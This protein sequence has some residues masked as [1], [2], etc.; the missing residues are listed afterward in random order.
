MPERQWQ[1][2][3]F[4]GGSVNGECVEVA[5]GLDGQICVRESDDPDVVMAASRSTWGAFLRS[6]K[7][8]V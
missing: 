1:K 4:S 7:A 2:S 5:V 6:I 8:D 3:S